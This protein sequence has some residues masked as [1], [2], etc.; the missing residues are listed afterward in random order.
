MTLSNPVLR[1]VPVD[2]QI[3][4]QRKMK[5]IMKEIQGTKTDTLNAFDQVWNVFSLQAEEVDKLCGVIEKEKENFRH[6]DEFYEIVQR[7]LTVKK[8]FT[9]NKE[10]LRK[11]RNRK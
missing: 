2:H 11:R 10:I 9:K 3:S 5:R 8:N 4:L 7:R 1:C 6:V